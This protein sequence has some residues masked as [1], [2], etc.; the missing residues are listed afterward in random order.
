MWPALQIKERAALMRE[1]PRL[2]LSGYFAF[3]K[4]TEDMRTR[5]WMNWK[6][7]HLYQDG[8]KRPHVWGSGWL[9]ESVKALETLIKDK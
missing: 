8:P 7:P 3:Q 1:R 2:H 5:C 4:Q 6:I 9:Q